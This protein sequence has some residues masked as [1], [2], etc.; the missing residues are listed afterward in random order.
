MTVPTLT[1]AFDLINKH[2]SEKES[3][4]NGLVQIHNMLK[5]DSNFD[6]ISLIDQHRIKYEFESFV[7]EAITSES[8]P[9]EIKSLYFGL[10][11]LG[12]DGLIPEIV[13]YG[14]DIS[15]DE[16]H[17]WACEDSFRPDPDNLQLTD[18]KIVASALFKSNIL[19]GS[20]EVLVFA[21]IL[22][23][24][25]IENLPLLKKKFVGEK[26]NRKEL[27]VGCG[28]FSGDAYLTAK[29]S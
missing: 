13:Y 23:L 6:L 20:V 5:I 22:N 27:W 28:Y 12:N 21:G 29:L 14:S 4:S 17:D 7:D 2:I 16:D 24:L 10:R 9:E 15:P 8:L 19:K 25:I 26:W 11:S 3:F 18:F 1:E